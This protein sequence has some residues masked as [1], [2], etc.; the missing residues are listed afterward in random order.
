MQFVGDL[1]NVAPGSEPRGTRLMSTFAMNFP[2]LGL[3]SRRRGL[4]LLAFEHDSLLL[5]GDAYAGML[6]MFSDVITRHHIASLPPLRL[7]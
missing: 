3:Q 7:F 2:L 4:N 6:R 1:C 5:L